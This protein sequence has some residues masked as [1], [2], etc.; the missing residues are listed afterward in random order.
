MK[1][2]QSFVTNSSSS[3]FVIAVRKGITEADLKKE[4][5]KHKKEIKSIL[6]DWNPDEL[7]VTSAI[8]QVAE[9]LHCQSR[10]GLELDDWNVAATEYSS[11]N[12]GIDYVIYSM[13]YIN[14]ENLKLTGGN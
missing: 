1:I 12:G 13:P 10:Y 6:D 4:L 14:S 5:T 7:S 8:Q 11:E 3:S 2:R 9:E